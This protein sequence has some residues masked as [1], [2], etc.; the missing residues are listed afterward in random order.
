MITWQ[1]Q[2]KDKN[3]HKE[4][5]FAG[6]III[7]LDKVIFLTL[8]GFVSYGTFYFMFILNM[9]LHFCHKKHMSW[10]FVMKG[11]SERLM[12]AFIEAEQMNTQRLKGP[13]K[14]N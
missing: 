14:K 7:D 3:R 8:L 6:T 5:K 9:E 4:S 10:Q 2:K 12:S 1:R 11:I 13:E